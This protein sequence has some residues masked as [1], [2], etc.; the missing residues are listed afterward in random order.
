[1]QPNKESA[2]QDSFKLGA[3]PPMPSLG[4]KAG[5]ARFKQ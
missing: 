3:L 1:M 2:A 5:F 4:D